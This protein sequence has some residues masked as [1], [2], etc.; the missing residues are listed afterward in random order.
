MPRDIGK[1]LE[2]KPGPETTAQHQAHKF[3]LMTGTG[4]GTGNEQ[5]FRSNSRRFNPFASDKDYSYGYAADP[6]IIQDVLTSRA[7]FQNTA[8]KLIQ[9]RGKDHEHDTRT[10]VSGSF[11]RSLYRNP[12]DMGN[13]VRKYHADD[14]LPTF[15]LFTTPDCQVDISHIEDI[16]KSVMGSDTP[17]W[18]LDKFRHLGGEV[19]QF[20]LVSWDQFKEIIPLAQAVTELECTIKKQDLP[21]H[22]RPQTADQYMA[23]SANHLVPYLHKSCYM[24]DHDISRL[25][26]DHY[27]SQTPTE[28]G[29][30][31]DLFIGTSKAT[32]HP[33]GYGGHIPLNTYNK[34]KEEHSK[35]AT[36]RPQTCYLRLGSERLGSVPNYSGYIPKHTGLEGER[37]TGMDPRTTAGSSYGRFYSNR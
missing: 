37:T 32:H 14:F 6:N 5:K 31:R 34:R 7:N 20:R 21:P 35:G 29:T 22:L 33:P 24:Y 2:T 26:D 8:A 12:L 23:T 19:A 16:V 11:S 27:I 9:E 17:Q 30:T 36:G 1:Y 25:D 28:N 13:E 15:E 3:R 10:N 4:T 18:I